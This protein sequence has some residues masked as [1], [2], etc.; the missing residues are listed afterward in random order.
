MPPGDRTLLLDADA[1]PAELADAAE[2]AIGV[3]EAGGTVIV[4]TDTVYGVAAHPGRAAALERLFALKGRERSKAMAVLAADADQALGLFAMAAL[5]GGVAEAVT[6]MTSTAWPGGLTV[7]GPRSDR[8]R[9][10]DLG[11]DATTIGVRVPDAAIV[12]SIAARIGP[13]VTTSANRSGDPTPTDAHSAARSLL[14]EVGLVVDAGRCGGLA[15][16]VVDV[17][18]T[19]FRVLRRGAVDPAT[20]GI[21]S[22]LLAPAD[23]VTLGA[24][25]E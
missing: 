21:D 13:I 15:S 9:H 1:D 20:L 3:L 22:L 19:P 7:V 23:A 5:A 24:P 8:W 10:V 16:T 14:D 17:T 11:G 4:P 6:A 25:R 18:V 2:R 12:R